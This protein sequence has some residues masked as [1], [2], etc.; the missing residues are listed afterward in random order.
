[1][2]W[3]R[4]GSKRKWMA[5]KDDLTEKGLSR[6]DHKGCMEVNNPTH[7][8]HIKVMIRLRV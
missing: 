3:E 4:E 7:R 5:I 1:M 2:C 8:P 6:E